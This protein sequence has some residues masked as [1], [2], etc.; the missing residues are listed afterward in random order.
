MVEKGVNLETV[1]HVTDPI[2]MAYIPYTFAELGKGILA[3]SRDTRFKPGRNLAPRL[4]CLWSRRARRESL[5][6]V[7]LMVR[8]AQAS[9]DSGLLSWRAPQPLIMERRGYSEIPAGLKAL[10]MMCIRFGHSEEIKKTPYKVKTRLP[11]DEGEISPC[12]VCGRAAR[13]A[14]PTTHRR[15]AEPRKRGE[16]E[17]R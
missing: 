7:F 6:L 9:P 5:L 15:S 17:A 10:F 1:G 8:A 4:L 3:R 13:A 16:M 2:V 14:P 12:S 11:R